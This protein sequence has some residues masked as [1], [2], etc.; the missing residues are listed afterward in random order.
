MLNRVEFVFDI[1]CQV[2]NP[3]PN[4]LVLE[5]KTRMVSGAVVSSTGN[6]L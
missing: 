1:L 5:A 4:D 3:N 6:S 2:C